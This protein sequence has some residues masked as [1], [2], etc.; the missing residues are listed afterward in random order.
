MIDS[1][2]ESYWLPKAWTEALFP[3][4]SSPGVTM[5]SDRPG[6]T[7][8]MMSPRIRDWKQEMSREPLPLSSPLAVMVSSCL[9]CHGSGDL[10]AIR[11]E[12]H[13]EGTAQL[14][15][16]ATLPQ[17]ITGRKSDSPPQMWK[18]L[19]TEPGQLPALPRPSSLLTFRL[20]PTWGFILV[21]MATAS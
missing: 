1:L 15:G 9:W 13:A 16:D 18:L 20:P 5:A 2:N 21:I 19:G 10:R 8:Q 14:L 12:G 7:W 3:P 4:P 17:I 6:G 11:G